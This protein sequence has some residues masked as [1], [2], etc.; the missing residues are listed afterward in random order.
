MDNIILN[1]LL[2]NRYCLVVCKKE[3]KEE[4]IKMVNKWVEHLNKVYKE[5]KK[6]NKSVSLSEAMKQAKKTYKK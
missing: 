1:R 6:K 3:K 2:F 4:K 5:M